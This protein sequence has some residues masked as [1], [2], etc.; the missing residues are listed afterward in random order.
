[1]S[2]RTAVAI[3]SLT[4]PACGDRVRV[5][6]I[7]D[8]GARVEFGDYIEIVGCG[9]PWHY[10]EDHQQVDLVCVCGHGRSKHLPNPQT[11]ST[12]DGPDGPFTG[13][14]TGWREPPR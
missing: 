7:S 13:S 6:L 11:C 8:W 14:C 4:C 3:P 12:C 10:V 5:T 9:N 2:E 1:M